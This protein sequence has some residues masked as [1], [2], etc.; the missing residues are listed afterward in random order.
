[1]TEVISYRKQE[2]GMYRVTYN[3]RIVG[4]D[5]A[6]STRDAVETE[7]KNRVLKDHSDAARYDR[8]VMYVYRPGF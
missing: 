3:N 7:A 2:N 8:P 4:D 6:Y 5:R 1:M